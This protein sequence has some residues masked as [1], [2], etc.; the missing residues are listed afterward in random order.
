MQ[1]KILLTA[2]NPSEDNDEEPKHW[3]QP[4]TKS[5]PYE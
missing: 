3:K 1:I 5:G 4:D 2:G